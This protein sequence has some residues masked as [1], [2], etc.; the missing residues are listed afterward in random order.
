MKKTTAPTGYNQALDDRRFAWLDYDRGISIIL[1]SFRHAYESLLNSGVHLHQYPF[2]EYINVFLFGFRMPLFFIAS[3]IFLSASLEKKGLNGYAASRVQTILYPMFVWGFIQLT[4]QILFSGVSN[5]S[6]GKMDY[7]WM[8]V[9]PRKTGQF[10]YLDTLFFVGLFY[11]I[12]KVKW[13]V[14]TRDQVLI[15]FILYFLLALLRANQVYLGLIMDIL[16]YYVFFAL[17]DMLAGWMKQKKTKKLLSS[18]GLLTLLIPLFMIIQSFFAKINLEQKDNYFVE[19]SMPVFFLLVASVGCLLSL[20]ISFILSKLDLAKYLRVIG[21]HSIYIYCMQIIFMAASR[22][23]LIK[24]FHISSVPVLLLGVL[25]SGVLVP[26]A[27]YKM[28]MNMNVWWLF[29]WKKPER[30]MQH[31]KPNN[32]PVVAKASGFSEVHT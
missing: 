8:I 21:Y 30:K 2:I 31:P 9:D 17:G 26:I 7:L 12:L 28:L 19:H 24:L 18:Y 23:I 13:R 20:N 27:A 4:L 16:Q 6:F 11:A 25:V 29:A 3:G 14:Q 5:T 32:F 10:W 15:G 22:L 1:V